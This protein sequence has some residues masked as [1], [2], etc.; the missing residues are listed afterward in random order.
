MAESLWPY[1][2]RREILLTIAR[3]PGNDR[4]LR[5]EFRTRSLHKLP[6]QCLDWASSMPG[7][8]LS[9]FKLCTVP[10]KPCSWGLMQQLGVPDTVETGRGSAQSRRRART[11]SR[12]LPFLLYLCASLP[13]FPSP[14][15]QILEG[16]LI[17]IAPLCLIFS[18]FKKTILPA[19]EC[20]VDMALLC[21][22]LQLCWDALNQR[23]ECDGKNSI[24]HSVLR[25]KEDECRI[26]FI[27]HRTNSLSTCNMAHKLW[28]C[29]SCINL[30]TILIIL[31]VMEHMRQDSSPQVQGS[32]K[33]WYVC[34]FLRQQNARSVNKPL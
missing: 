19:L 34:L 5:W 29:D 11:C 10:L 24:M 12:L 8:A 13:F 6:L 21:Y 18:G 30:R 15:I 7:K 33:L 14:R 17:W 26:N 16:M 20:E 27:L 25:V 32:S 9:L 2:P 1:W 3:K 28:H 22:C 23:C 4:V 31:V